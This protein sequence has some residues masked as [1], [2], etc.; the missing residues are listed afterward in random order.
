MIITIIT[1]FWRKTLY[2]IR[3]EAVLHF[4]WLIN[5]KYPWGSG[6]DSAV[7]SFDSVAVSLGSAYISDC[8]NLSPSAT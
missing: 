8:S 1:V 2:L 5:S 3:N 7:K 4:M 6:V